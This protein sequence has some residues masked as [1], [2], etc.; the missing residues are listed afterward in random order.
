MTG[1]EQRPSGYGTEGVDDSVLGVLTGQVPVRSMPV[2]IG[3]RRSGKTRATEQWL[4]EREA[5]DD[6]ERDA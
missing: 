2:A 4:A 1:S 6:D 5:E 3:G